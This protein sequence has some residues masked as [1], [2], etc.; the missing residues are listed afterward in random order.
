MPA[1]ASDGVRSRLH[2]TVGVSQLS[3]PMSDSPVSLAME[4]PECQLDNM[5]VGGMTVTPS[6]C[7]V[8]ALTA[9]ALAWRRRL[10]SFS[11]KCSKPHG[12]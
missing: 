6:P 3:L 9:S 11:F 10:F 1:T 2:R 7:A 12:Y 8:P 4:L 5:T